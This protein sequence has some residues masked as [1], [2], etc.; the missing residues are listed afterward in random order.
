[1]TWPKSW[2]NRNH[3]VGIANEPYRDGMQG[4]LVEGSDDL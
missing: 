1:M 3:E 2:V 4:W